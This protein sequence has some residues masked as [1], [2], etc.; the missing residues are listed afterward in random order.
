MVIAGYTILVIYEFVPLYKQKQWKDLWVN[1]GLGLFSLCI[2]VL[3]CFD[4]KIPSPA[5]PIK[6]VITSVFGK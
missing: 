4:I 2:A 6:D 1:A 5:D 3:L